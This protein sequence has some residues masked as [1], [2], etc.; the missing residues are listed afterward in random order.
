MSIIV[1]KYGG[2]SVS[3][4]EGRNII[5]SNAKK[6]ISSG[7]QLV[8]VVSAMGRMGAPYATDT[9]IHMYQ[10][11]HY[12]MN[13]IDLDLLMSCGETISAA[14]ISN[15][16]RGQGIKARALTGYQAGIITDNI[17]GNATVKKVNTENITKHLDRG[18]VVIVTGFQGIS[19]LGDITTLGRGGSDTTAAILGEVLAAEYIEIY[20]DVDGVMTADPRH[21]GDAKVLNKISYEEM[22]QMALD[23]AKVVDPKAVA[24]AKRS[25][26]PLIIKNTFSESSGTLIYGAHVPEVKKIVTAVAYKNDIIQVK[27]KVD[28]YDPRFE[29]LLQDIE[30]ANISIDLISFLENEKIFTVDHIHHITMLNL[31]SALDLTTQ[32]TEACSKVTVIG[33]GIHGVPGVMKRVALALTLNKVNILQTADSYTTISCLVREQELTKA[34]QALHDEFGLND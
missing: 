33:H 1:Q 8:I 20:T 9:L 10:Q 4:D 13:T 21:V 6:V 15:W 23:G 26:R 14:Y 3:T 34:I 12:E 28:N 11:P 16:L 5:V 18:Y 31:T 24:I 2:T 7:D 19:E 30:K 22:H 17:A 32:I 29:R 25:N 27:V